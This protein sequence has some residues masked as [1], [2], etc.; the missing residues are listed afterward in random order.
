MSLAIKE[1]QIK[2]T[3]EIPSH[4]SQIGSYQENTTNAGK[5][6]GVGGSPYI[7]LVGM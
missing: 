2:T 5:D 4:P 6:A 7:W 1:M 3:L